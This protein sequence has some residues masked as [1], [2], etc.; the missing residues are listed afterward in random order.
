MNGDK[1][2]TIHAETDFSDKGQVNMKGRLIW[3]AG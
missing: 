3:R 2:V 1:P